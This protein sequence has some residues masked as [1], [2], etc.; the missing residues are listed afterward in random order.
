[1]GE[2]A[3]DAEHR[4]MDGWGKFG[5]RQVGIRRANGSESRGR[6]DIMGLGG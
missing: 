1:M 4:G 6:G 3:G 2:G 5:Q